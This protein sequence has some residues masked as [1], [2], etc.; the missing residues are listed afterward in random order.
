MKSKYLLVFIPISIT[1]YSYNL[2]IPCFLATFLS[3]IPLAII[4]CDYTEKVASSLGTKIGG[5]LSAS[6][7][8]LPELLICLFAINSGMFDLV[9]A[10]II[11][12]IIGNMLLVQGISIF[13]GGVKYKEQRFNKNIARTNFVLLSLSIIGILV[14]SLCSVA[15]N[16]S[17]KINSLSVYISIILIILYF[18]GLFFSLGTHKSLFTEE[19]AT[20]EVE[21]PVNTKKC[22]LVFLAIAIVM[23]FQSNIL[24]NTLEYISESFNI[25]QNFLGIIVVPLV[26][27]IGEYAT[28]ISMA[29]RNKINLCIEISIGSS[30]Q[31][32]LLCA[33]ILVIASMIM[34]TPLSLVFS[35][36]HILC[37]LIALLLAY[38]V[39]QDGKTYWIEG[40]I[41]ISAYLI[42]AIGYYFM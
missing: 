24:V 38:L 21:T 31:I 26:G 32:A 25:S 33:P 41:M 16:V 35:T 11:G 27:N 2:Y 14:A 12:S 34:G 39:F 22:L 7:G 37:L 3:I 19:V 20:S 36:Y 5:F 42:L 18:M 17:D 29:L 15:L 1:L 28:A 10:G 4:L 8:N 30:M 13:A 40:S 6:T 9:K 23:V